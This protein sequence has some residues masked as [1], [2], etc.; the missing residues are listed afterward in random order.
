VNH[1]ATAWSGIGLVSGREPEKVDVDGDGVQWTM[2]WNELE[3]GQP[4]GGT[5]DVWAM[6]AN[7]ANGAWGVDGK[8]AIAANPL[9]DEAEPAVAFYGNAATRTSTVAWYD[10]T[11]RPASVLGGTNLQRGGNLRSGNPFATGP[12]SG[13]QVRW[14]SFATELSGGETSADGLLAFWANN[15]ATLDGDVYVQLHRAHLGG[16]FSTITAGCSG[17]GHVELDYALAFGRR[18]EIRLRQADPSANLG[19]LLVGDPSSTRISCGSCTLLS[20]PLVVAVGMSSGAAAFSLL[21]PGDPSFTG[22]NLDLQFAV[23]GP[24]IQACALVPGLAASDIL[25]ATIRD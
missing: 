22:V 17:G 20:T 24:Q 21:V 9:D 6:T 19:F 16:P 12:T 23:I 15:L 25:R 13:F 8:R 11:A 18:T 1:D 7:S 3:A 10:A 14:P 5:R 2:V 4:A